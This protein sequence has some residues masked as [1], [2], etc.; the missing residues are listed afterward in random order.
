MTIYA[1]QFIQEAFGK[2]TN[3]HS[4]HAEDLVH[5][6]GKF[7]VNW[8]LETLK[9]IFSD[10]QSESQSSIT[11]SVKIDGAPA[12]MCFM[13]FPG[14]EG[15]GVAT[16]GLF[17]KN[18]K[19]A[20]TPED[21]QVLYG[22]AP[23]LVRKM[24]KLLLSIPN[25][26][27]P[28]G[29][30]WQG[31]FLYDSESLSTEMIGGEKCLTFQPNTI[32][33][34]V[35]LDSALAD[36]IANSDIGIAFHTRY[37]GTI[38][39]AKANYNAKVSELNPT[40]GVFMT[41]PYIPSLSGKV[42]FSFEESNYINE[43]LSV[44]E[45]IINSLDIEDIV[46]N[47]NF[48]MLFST[49]QNTLVRQGT[50]VVDPKEFYN[51]FNSW[52]NNRVQKEIDSKKTEKGKIDTQ[53]KFD[54]YLSLA[55]D[56]RIVMIVEL[57]NIL[58]N[59]KSKFIEKLNY[60]GQFKTYLKTLDGNIMTTNQEGFMISDQ[61]GNAVKLVDRGEFSKMNFDPNILKGWQKNAEATISESVK[62]F[63]EV[64][65]F[66]DL[67]NVVNSK[68]LPIRTQT[69]KS[70]T[71][72]VPKPERT[73]ITKDLASELISNDTPP[74]SEISLVRKDKD[75]KIDKF[76]IS[77]KP[78][79]S[80]EG[81]KGHTFE[82]NVL[83]VLKLKELSEYSQEPWAQELLH[84]LTVSELDYT[85]EDVEKVGGLNVRR[86]INWSSENLVPL[87]EGAKFGDFI[88]I[89]R[90]LSDIN[91]Y[92]DGGP[93]DILP[94]SVKYGSSLAFL[95]CGFGSV[96]G[97][98]DVWKNNFRKFFSII[99][100]DI[101]IDRALQA[102]DTNNAV[103]LSKEIDNEVVLT[104]PP[105]VTDFIN[106]AIGEGYLYVHN[107][108]VFFMS[109]EKRI[110]LSANPRIK[111]VIYPVAPS[112]GFEIALETDGMTVSIKVRDKVGRP[113]GA[114]AMMLEKYKFK[115]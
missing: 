86:P 16:K 31:D 97:N 13:S 3:L 109:T 70:L 45:E 83:D 1:K 55:Q 27:I 41:D 95:N 53:Q 21:C 25:M 106:H 88:A 42:K 77:T 108:H 34:A 52:L 102:F 29:E 17:A 54:P 58:T 103:T 101:N 72:E 100:P 110:L 90:A 75:I 59:L 92:G 38:D 107:K 98:S 104:N 2:G 71:V 15:P 44:C 33:Y 20:R 28:E 112:D 49:Y 10:L 91:I 60:L 85:E 14:L 64:Y 18:P 39:N 46:Q 50:Q 22:H 11:K 115:E 63:L 82:D 57:I 35:P 36:E 24:Q 81:N 76:T 80:L 19:Y 73:T 74:E 114:P 62:E 6:G 61:E 94:I 26:G 43:Q 12:A 87:P 96:K 32:I 5:L 113:G 8:L 78:L 93:E 68:G 47:E 9:N 51:G 37:T 69:S 99:S 111:Y 65:S 30:V 7:G 105:F 67:K 89:G 79:G 48:T 56:E 84:L 66:D 40:P 23:D 4:T